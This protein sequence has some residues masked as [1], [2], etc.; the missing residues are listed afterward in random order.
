MTYREE[1]ARRIAVLSNVN[2]DPVL[3]VLNQKRREQYGSGAEPV[4]SPDGYGN[5]FE[6][7]LRPDSAVYTQNAEHIYVILDLAELL[8]HCQ[9]GAQIREEV[10]RWFA[11]FSSCI[12]DGLQYFL[13][14]AD[15]RQEWLGMGNAELDVEGI[16]ALWYLRLD[17]CRKAHPNVRLFPLRRLIARIGKRQAYAEKMWYLGRIPFGEEARR[18]L[19]EEILRCEQTDATPKKALLLDLDGTLWGGVAGED[20]AEGI[21]LGEEKTGLIYRDVQRI[22]KRMQESGVI[23]CIVSK[24]N[25]QDVL[26]LFATHPH[27]VLHEEDFAAMRINWE[28]KDENIRALAQELNLGMDSFVFLDDNPAE[29]A[30][31]RARLPEVAVPDFPQQ[32]EALPETVLELFRRYFAKW[33][34][35][36]ED[37]EK[38]AQYRANAARSALERETEARAG[39]A[40]DGYAAFLE[41]LEIRLRRVDERKNSARLLQLLNKTNQFNLTTRRYTEAELEQILAQREHYSVYLFD[42]SDRFGSNGMTAAVIVALEAEARVEAFVMSCRIMGRQ[43][44]NMVLDYVEADLMRRGRTQLWGVYVATPKSKPVETFYEQ[45]GFTLLEEKDG[46]KE[47]RK[48]LETIGKAWY[49]K[50]EAGYCPQSDAGLEALLQERNITS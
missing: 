37:R 2:L 32:I 23:L 40:E 36:G 9:S 27:M 18:A 6:A 10:D 48:T 17:E 45:S 39:Q 46:R 1:T 44:E 31:I 3:A 22:L 7:L 50:L 15:C 11:T 24:N 38:T 12:R 49:G 21:L 4:V 28:P 47:Y 41:Q 19:A 33:V 13:S 20:G 35:T 26:P 16:E 14:D 34:Y 8:K 43:I 42:V 30:L 25:P 29:R 5:V